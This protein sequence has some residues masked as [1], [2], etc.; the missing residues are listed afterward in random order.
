MRIA[1]PKETARGELR[2]AIIPDSVRRLVKHGYE[3]AVESGAGAGAHFPDAAFQEAGAT[4]EPSVESLLAAADTVVKIQEPSPQEVEA[5]RA[6]TKLV[7]LLLP[8]VNLDLVR[9]LAAKKITA[10]A[11][12]SIPRTSLAQTMDVLSSQATVAGYRAVILAA[13]TVPKLFPMLMT[14]AGTLAP[15]RVLILGAGVAGL[16][17]IATSKRLGAVVEAFDIRRAVKQEV[18]SLGA[19]FIEVETLEDAAGEGGYAKEVS[20]EFKRREQELIRAHLA[21]ADI[22]IT[23]A[24]VPG[25]RAPILV[26]EEMVQAMRPGSV[27]VDLAAE[28]GGNCAL[29]EPGTDVVRHGV[30]IAGPVNLPSSTAIHASQMYSRNMENL[31][32]HLMRPDR[33]DIDFTDEI[34]RGCVITHEGQIVHPRIR[35][36][37][38]RGGGP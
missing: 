37:V 28:Q 17:A 16:Q 38:T 6:G 22:C 20:E 27:I 8:L 23:T 36:S 5:L 30:S 2:V 15:A 25:K 1:V 34:A 9:T 35:D 3:I 18:E 31:L 33:P 7:S 14:A 13:Q 26:T 32:L 10:I 19:R 21:K 29:T 11:V 24:L 4:I 12:D